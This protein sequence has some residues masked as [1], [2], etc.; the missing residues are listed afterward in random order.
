MPV[1]LW[2][3]LLFRESCLVLGEKGFVG[4]ADAWYRKLSPKNAKVCRPTLFNYIYTREE[5]DHYTGELFR[6]MTEKNFKVRIHKIYPLK[7]VAQ[8]HNVSFICCSCSLC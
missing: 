8:A 4:F 1:G 2:S 7:N 3:R 6:L 5:L